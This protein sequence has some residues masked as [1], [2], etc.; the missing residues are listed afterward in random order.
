M[1]L[2]PEN[3][4]HC[5]LPPGFD[6]SERDGAARCR[7]FSLK[8]CL[9]EQFHW[10]TLQTEDKDRPNHSARPAPRERGGDESTRIQGSFAAGTTASNSAH[11]R[12]T[13]AVS[14]LFYSPNLC[15][16]TGLQR[17][18]CLPLAPQALRSGAVISIFGLDDGRHLAPGHPSDI[19]W[20]RFLKDALT[21]LNSCLT[22][23]LGILRGAFFL[24]HRLDNL[25]QRCRDVKI[26]VWRGREGEDFKKTRHVVLFLVEPGMQTGYIV[27]ISRPPPALRS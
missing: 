11:S 23:T 21:S 26:L 5:D 24:W 20:E 7:C 13:I 15:I 2:G 3:V 16:H 1:S 8:L 14:P 22:L 9:L 12:C 25:L 18:L 4:M 19:K 6:L 27:D 17:L 10:P